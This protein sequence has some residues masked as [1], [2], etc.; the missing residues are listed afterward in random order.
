MANVS[1]SNFENISSVL[2]TIDE[3]GRINVPSSFSKF[4]INC[5]CIFSKANLQVLHQSIL[6]D[7]LQVNEEKQSTI[8]SC[9]IISNNCRPL[10]CTP[11]TMSLWRI[12]ALQS[13]PR[14]GRRQYK[15]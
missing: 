10:A 1:E 3:C 14:P 11:V 5:T 8:G 12:N 6:T 2:Y 4:G 7:W 15:E 13:W 9:C